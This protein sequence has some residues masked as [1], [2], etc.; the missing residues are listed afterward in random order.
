M[1]S[2]SSLE[3]VTIKYLSDLK[4]DPDT[5]AEIGSCIKCFFFCAQEV[6]ESKLQ[7]DERLAS[8]CHSKLTHYQYS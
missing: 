8:A 3:Y 5:E 7:L 1:D 2:N 4:L 6:S